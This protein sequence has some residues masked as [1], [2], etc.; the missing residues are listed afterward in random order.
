MPCFILVMREVVVF[1]SIFA[2]VGR[3]WVFVLV[4]F[5]FRLFSFLFV[6]V[7]HFL[8]QHF[9]SF[10]AFPFSGTWLKREGFIYDF[11]WGDRKSYL[12]VFWGCWLLEL[13]VW[14]VWGKMKTQWIYHLFILL[15][16]NPY[17]VCILLSSF[18]SHLFVL[19]TMTGFS[20]EIYLKDILDRSSFVITWIIIKYLDILLSDKLPVGLFNIS[21]W[22]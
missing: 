13:Q 16:F 22:K 1:H 3:S 6:R 19:H 8:S 12:L 14:D 18:W 20:C 4:L 15:V 21:Q 2:G 17:L 7:E 5:V 11:F 10:Q 9:L